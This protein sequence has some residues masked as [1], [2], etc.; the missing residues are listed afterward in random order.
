MGDMTMSR[1]IFITESDK[2][3]LLKIINKAQHED[4]N[5]NVNLKDLEAEIT[6]ANVTSIDELPNNVI[7]MNSTAI[8]LIEGDEEEY[9]LVYPSEADIS[10]NKISV[11]SPIGTAIL[12]YS[13][14]DIVKWEVPKGTVDINIKKVLFQPEASGNYDL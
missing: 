3:K 10:K 9:T 2:D 14:G 5:D 12:G 6:R 13:E 11:L 8:L 4:F 1:K 7:T